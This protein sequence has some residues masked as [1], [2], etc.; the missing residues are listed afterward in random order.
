MTARPFL[1][2]AACLAAVGA[3]WTIGGATGFAVVLVVGVVA[4]AAGRGER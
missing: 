3:I 4:M 2:S 1:L